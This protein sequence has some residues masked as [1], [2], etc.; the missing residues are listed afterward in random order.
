M[1]LRTEALGV[2]CHWPI[3]GHLP[4]PDLGLRVQRHRVGVSQPISSVHLQSWGEITFQRKHKGQ[5][6]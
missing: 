5:E 2:N 6:S 3:L 4:A 1:W